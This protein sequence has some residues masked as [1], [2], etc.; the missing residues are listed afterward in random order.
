MLPGTANT[1]PPT[2]AAGKAIGS[3]GFFHLEDFCE[4]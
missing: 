3:D 4:G 1:M 2:P